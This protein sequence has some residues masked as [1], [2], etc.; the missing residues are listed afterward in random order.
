MSG[1]DGS[2]G[3][4][5]SS[6]G[7]IEKN[8]Q[9]ISKE[10]RLIPTFDDYKNHGNKRDQVFSAMS[11]DGS[12]KVT[13]CTVRNLVNDMMMAHQLSPT[14]AEVLSRTVVCALLMSNGMQDEQMVQISFQG[15]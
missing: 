4:S 3:S 9:R 8:G 1:S 10:Q 12:V 7:D 13:A 6:Q 2:D 11:K 5:S 14:S 15:E